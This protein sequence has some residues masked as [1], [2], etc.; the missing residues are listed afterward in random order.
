MF[1]RRTGAQSD[2]HTVAHKFGGFQGGVPLFSI[3]IV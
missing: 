3:E 1:G 2:D